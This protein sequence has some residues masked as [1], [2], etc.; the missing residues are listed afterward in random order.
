MS[1]LRDK[2]REEVVPA[3]MQRFQ[4]KSVMQVPR[5]VKIVLNM[6]VGEAAHDP[7]EL[8]SAMRDLANIT[9]QKPAVARAKKSVAAFRIR[10]GMPIGCY[11]TLRGQRMYDFLDK[12]IHLALPQV[13]DFRGVSPRSFDGRGNYSIGLREQLV[14]PEMR[15][16]DV[17][18]I[19]G[20]DISIVT[21]AK[22]DEEAFE[23]L[24]A[25]GLPFRAA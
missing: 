21:T 18:K 24:K 13:R 7:K 9:G 11:V 12:F 3:L 4:Y 14:F 8:E 20:L 19:R 15:I 25:L 1:R 6:G 5:L 17:D 16:G 22:N 10:E 2:Y 23:L